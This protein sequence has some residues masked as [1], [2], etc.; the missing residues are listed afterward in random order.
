MNE[1]RPT[2]TDILLQKV[3]ST[4]AAVAPAKEIISLTKKE[5]KSV[6]KN[7]KERIVETSNTTVNSQQDTSDYVSVTGED[8]SGIDWEYQL[9]DPPSAF[10]DNSSPPYYGFKAIP[11]TFKDPIVINN[12]EKNQVIDRKIKINDSSII[13][14]ST[15][16][17]S[18][19]QN[20]KIPS[21]NSE[22][23]KKPVYIS[24]NSRE[25]DSTMMLKK[26]MIL[27][28]ETK[29]ENGCL[30]KDNNNKLDEIKGKS[31]DKK[32]QKLSPSD[33]TLSNFTITTYSRP[34]NMN[35]YYENDSSQPSKKS[36]EKFVKTFATLSRNKST[37][38][39]P[40]KKYDNFMINSNN[41]ISSTIS[42]TQSVKTSQSTNVEFK[43]P[44]FKKN[45]QDIHRSKSY[46]SLV[47][48]SK[49]RDE[50]NSIDVVDEG[51]TIGRATSYTNLNQENLINEEG[52]N[53]TVSQSQNEASTEL[54]S[55]QVKK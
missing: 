19:Q 42:R 28:L 18:H 52:K 33:N 8:L 37:T 43:K 21:N 36:D 13:K 17:N 27:E 49:Y 40:P 24:Q 3:S 34:Q 25:I 55:V 54:Q 46:I 14:T 38:L 2:E 15:P 10:R 4:L 32:I 35:I 53:E 50:K 48:N 12:Y 16:I 22:I 41:E 44:V 30:N 20:E 7:E 11:E 5:E 23:S 45:E 9:P 1:A 31:N 39:L 29:I 26:D 47:N 51:K 6:E